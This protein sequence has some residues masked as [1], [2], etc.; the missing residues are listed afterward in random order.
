VVFVRDSLIFSITNVK[1]PGREVRS[2]RAGLCSFLDLN[3]RELSDEYFMSTSS[4]ELRLIGLLRTS[5]NSFMAK[6]A[7]F[8]FHAFR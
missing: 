8:L 4:T 5:E 1:V 3:F 2:V 6:F 7:E